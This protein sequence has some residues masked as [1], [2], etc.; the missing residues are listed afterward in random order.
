MPDLTQSVKDPAFVT[1]AAQNWRCCGIGW[2]LQLQFQP[3]AWELTYATG[4][5]LKI[6]QK[7]QNKTKKTVAMNSMKHENY[8]A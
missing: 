1:D 5:A 2:K 4:V 7:K 8:E 6:R 3:L